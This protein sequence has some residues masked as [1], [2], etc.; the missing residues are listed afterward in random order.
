MAD[1][2]KTPA[3]DPAANLSFIPSSQ[4]LTFKRRLTYTKGT[5]PQ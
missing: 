4:V 5:V 2:E 1:C 3:N